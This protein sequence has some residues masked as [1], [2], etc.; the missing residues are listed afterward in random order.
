MTEKAEKIPQVSEHVIPIPNSEGSLLVPN[1]TNAHNPHVISTYSTGRILC[2]C[3]NDKTLSISLSIVYAKHQKVQP[4]FYKWLKK[5]R[6]SQGSNTINFSN[7]VSGDMPHGRGQKGKWPPRTAKARVTHTNTWM[8]ISA[9]TSQQQQQ[10]QAWQQPHEIWSKQRTQVNQE[11]RLSYPQLEIQSDR[12]LHVLR[13]Q[14]QGIGL[15]QLTGLHQQ[16]L[17][18]Q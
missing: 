6:R 16:Y 14:Q 5:L 17:A 12:Q 2:N 1:K 13:P 4:K 3:I 15:Q 18:I 9:C 7:L 11:T 8:N 10:T